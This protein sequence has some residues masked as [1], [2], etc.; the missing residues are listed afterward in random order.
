[1]KKWVICVLVM[2]LSGCTAPRELE[3]VSD[4]YDVTTPAAGVILFDMPSEASEAV[5]STEGM[6]SLY[7]CDGYTLTAQTLPGGDLNRTLET[8]T[9]FGAEKLT[10][11]E[12]EKDGLRSYRTV[13]SSAG[14]GGD[15][16]GRAMILGDGNYHYVLS[17]MACAEEAAV[18]TENWNA[19][20][21]SFAISRTAP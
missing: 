5:F 1:M 7:L 19:L 21:D 3:T 17:V 13:W 18:L 15:Q 11:L 16:L 8:V 9:G 2:L 20:F 10:V 6:G 12:T 14:E 4:S